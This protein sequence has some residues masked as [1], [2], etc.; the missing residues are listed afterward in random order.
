[1][2]KCTDKNLGMLLHDYELGLLSE[3]DT[4]RFEMHLYECEYCLT[5]VR[6]NLDVSRI[7]I[8]DQDTHAL[9]ENV[10]GKSEPTKV[11]KKSSPFL[12]LL[13]A[14]V[15]AMLIFA[16]VYK[17]LIHKE[18]ST[19]IQTLELLPART[20]GNDIIYLDKGGDVRINFFFAEEFSAPVNL[21]ILKVDGD[22]VLA[23][24]DFTDF[25]RQGLGT[26]TVPVTDFSEGHYILHI[27]PTSD[28]YGQNERQYM[29]KVK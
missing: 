8:E 15:L 18:P 10:A 17:Y 16:P 5:Q 20:G 2:S 6:E 27:Q 14:A 26:I 12:R 23:L 24:E 29:F 7:I 21:T 9:I 22:T 3:E 11:K 4:H 13:I 28:I 25:N 19:V 1:M